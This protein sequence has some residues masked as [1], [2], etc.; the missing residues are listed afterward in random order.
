MDFARAMSDGSPI[1]TAYAVGSKYSTYSYSYTAAY[2]TGAMPMPNTMRNVTKV[3]FIHYERGTMPTKSAST[4]KRALLPVRMSH[5][6]SV[7]LVPAVGERRSEE[8][9]VGKECRS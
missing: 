7:S 1:D 4:T 3:F 5:V 9:R 6:V 8:R 2:A